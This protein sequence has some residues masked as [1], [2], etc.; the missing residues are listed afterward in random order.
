MFAQL[1]EFIPERDIVF[2]RDDLIIRM[3]QKHGL[4][5][6]DEM[7][8]AAHNRDF[9][10]KD[11]KMLVK[12]LNMYRDNYNIL[13]G[14]VPFFY[15]LDPQVRKFVALRVTIVERGHAILQ[16]AKSSMFSNDPWE[17]DSNK[18]I[19]INMQKT[20]K[21]G[22]KIRTNFSK[23]TTF[24][25]HLHYGALSKSQEAR[26][27]KIKESKRN[28]LMGDDVEPEKVEKERTAL[29]N[30]AE[31]YDRDMIARE[32]IEA[33]CRI[34]DKKYTSTMLL[35]RRY[36]KNRQIL[37]PNKSRPLLVSPVP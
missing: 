31:K 30:L 35:I 36:L 34:N 15:D 16:K 17:T 3:K 24:W 2:S 29:E 14:A 21:R 9:Y 8:N 20:M 11:Q 23:L 7:I 10:E 5:M 12:M 27:H 33:Y 32:D 6:Q 13:A 37:L 28:T 1:G 25:G 4:I 18:K 19:E 26:Y 22:Q